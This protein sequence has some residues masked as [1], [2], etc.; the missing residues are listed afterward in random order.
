MK[1]SGIKRLWKILI[2]PEMLVLPGQLAFFLLL[3]IVPT[4]TLI[5]YG[6]SLFNVSVDFLSNFLI[7]SFQCI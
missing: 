1:E 5:V 6:V 7:K 3:A 2:R 4:I